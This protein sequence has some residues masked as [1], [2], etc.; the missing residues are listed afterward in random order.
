MPRVCTICAHPDREA[1]EK[2]MVA[3]QPYRAI[4]RQWR[5]GRD[6]LRNHK[7]GHLPA[8]LV[9]A[10]QAGERDRAEELRE[11]ARAQEA[12]EEA[13]AL[14][15]M[16]ELRGLFVTVH[17]LRDACDRWLRD[18]DDPTKFTLEPRSG[19]IR[20]VYTEV[21]ADGKERRCKAPLDALLARLSEAGIRVNGWETRRA[22]P[23]ELLLKTAGQ[24]QGQ[25][26]LLAQLLGE[27]DK[28]P[29]VNVLVSP[30]WLAVRSLIVEALMPFPEARSVVSARLLAL[31][32]N[33]EHRN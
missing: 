4:A 20:V 32:S 22:D 24:L 19:E 2:A 5:V 6:A 17:L 12:A 23:R 11:Q 33:G 26:D 3:S 21:G 8:L 27:L 15:V 13:L 30:E 10:V 29:R 14:D 7:E 9:K 18:P 31:E 25:I 1:I 28:R 16:G